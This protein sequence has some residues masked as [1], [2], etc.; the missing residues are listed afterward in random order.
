MHSAIPAAT[1]SASSR[2]YFLD[3]VRVLAFFVLIAYHVA[4]TT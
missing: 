3:W 4:C 2:L 1:P